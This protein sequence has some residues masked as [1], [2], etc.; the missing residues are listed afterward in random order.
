MGV[1]GGI[2]GIHS[3]HS[4]RAG[5]SRR[6]TLKAFHCRTMDRIKTSALVDPSL[7]KCAGIRP[8]VFL[9]FQLVVESS[10]KR[11]ITPAVLDFYHSFFVGKGGGSS[12]ALGPEAQSRPPIEE[13]PPSPRPQRT[14]KRA[15]RS[16]KN[17]GKV[18]RK[19]V[20][21]GPLVAFFFFK[22]KLFGFENQIS[23]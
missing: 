12:P 9:L 20:A 17:K 14:D 7:H 3:Q 4:T 1:R 18:L 5:S 11:F 21:P 13:L 2:F 22:F 23:L 16:R 15:A 8:G 6:A 19:K 10:V